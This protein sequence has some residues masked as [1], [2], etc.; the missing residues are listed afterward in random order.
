[1]AVTAVVVTLALSAGTAGAFQCPTLIKQGRDAAAK[2]DAKDAYVAYTLHS[3]SSP[4]CGYTL[5]FNFACLFFELR[6]IIGHL[7]AEPDLRA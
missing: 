3:H 7:H 4:R 2:M 6:E 5:D 1:M